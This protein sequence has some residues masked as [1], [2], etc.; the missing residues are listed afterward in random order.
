MQWSYVIET[1]EIMAD[2]D[3]ELHE[4]TLF[5]MSALYS[6]YLRISELAASKRWTPQMG[7]FF[8]DRD[9][10]YWFKVVGKGNKERLISVSN[11]M[12]N[13]LKRY[14]ISLNLYP[15]P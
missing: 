3:S 4:R 8:R 7:H 5:I 9:G 14:R 10:F 15:L 11:A 13:A 1:A 2:E 6:M 12:L